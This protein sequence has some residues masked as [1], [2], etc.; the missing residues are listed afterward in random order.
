MDPTLARIISAHACTACDNPIAAMLEQYYDVVL[1]NRDPEADE[2]DGGYICRVADEVRLPVPQRPSGIAEAIQTCIRQGVDLNAARDGAYPLKTAVNQLDPLMV[3][4]LIRNG[5][6][7]SRWQEEG[8]EQNRW[9]HNWYLDDVDFKLDSF[10]VELP[11]N[12]DPYFRDLLEMARIL[13]AEGRLM[14]DYRGNCL[15]V[16]I[17]NR[18]ISI[19]NTEYSVAI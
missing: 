19:R 5:A 15:L 16:D 18:T 3:R 10:A 17:R 9:E 7:C 1:R 12:V 14:E 13:V 6:D 4:Y 2:E 8:I 11:V